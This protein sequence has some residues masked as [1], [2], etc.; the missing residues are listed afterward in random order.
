MALVQSF[1]T[2]SS[3]LRRY[4]KSPH[5]CTMRNGFLHNGPTEIVIQN[6]NPVKRSILPQY[7]QL[8][9]TAPA[10]RS[11]A[12][13][14]APKKAP[15]KKPAPKKRSTGTQSGLMPSIRHRRSAWEGVEL[16]GVQTTATS[17]ASA[18]SEFTSTPTGGST[19]HR[20]PVLRL[21]STG[22]TK[23][24]VSRNAARVTRSS[25]PGA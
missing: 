15:R 17:G 10:P 24:G 12:K 19:A 5:P 1:S 3:L 23:I 4:F 14:P 2:R 16:K 21:S 18:V 8:P 25:G 11:T 6:P 9:E 20:T 13:G 22:I 7:W